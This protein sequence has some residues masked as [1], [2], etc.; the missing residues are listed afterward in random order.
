MEDASERLARERAF[1]DDRFTDESRTAA[2]KYYSVTR[3]SKEHLDAL[4][5]TARKGDTALELG[6]GLD[7]TALALA[8]RGV[9]VMAIDISEVAIAAFHERAS[10]AGLADMVSGCV[11]NAE[12]LQFDDQCFDLVF[13]TGILHHLDSAAIF[14]ELSRVLRR[15]GR[16]AF[17]E[18]LGNNPAVNLYRRL[19]PRMRTPDEHPLIDVDF[20]IA[21][22]CF[23]DVD[24]S[25][26]HTLSLLAVPFRRW[27]RFP[28][29]LEALERGDEAL[30]KRIPPA[31]AL[32]WVCVVELAGPRL[33]SHGGRCLVPPSE[34]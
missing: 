25:Y 19:T 16:G 14:A 18:P 33:G 29:V 21:E 10:D 30:Y 27:S 3:A 34:S 7:G 24:V 12:D 13:G 8:R 2:K 17:L 6:C 15:G 4:L 28:Q 26:F 11:M 22:R 5:A 1:H 23:E 9:N 31:K 20:E 32:A